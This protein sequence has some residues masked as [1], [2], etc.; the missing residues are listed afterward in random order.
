M[1][2][3][4]NVGSNGL[5]GCNE[6]KKSDHIHIFF[7][8]NAKNV[9]WDIVKDIVKN[10]GEAEWEIHEVPSGKQSADIHL[11]SYLGYLIGM[12][13]GQ[14]CA[15]IIVSKDKDFDKVIEF[16]IES[17]DA[18]VSRIEM[19]KQPAKED[20]KSSAKKENSAKK[21]A[22]AKKETGGKPASKGRDTAKTELGQ[23]VQLALQQAGYKG[24]DVDQISKVVIDCYDVDHPETLKSNVH[25]GLQKEYDDE[26]VQGIYG[27]IKSVLNEYSKMHAPAGGSDAGSDKT[28]LNNI[29]QQILS[30]AKM[31]ADVIGFVT[32]TVVKNIGV[33]N[34]KQMIYRTIISKYGQKKGLDIYN[35]IKKYIP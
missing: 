1:I 13:S 33:K 35:R 28:A 16:W 34:G 8:K 20:K 25:N 4:E 27:N 29:V 9:G 15:Y 18:K 17:Q 7:T 21:A 5:S 23:K 10:H 31:S 32:S 24:D 6:L 14:D 3:Y 30:K 26:T 2:D 22:A 11:S 12:N 19:I